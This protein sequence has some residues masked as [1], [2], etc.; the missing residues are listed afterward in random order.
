MNLRIE[1]ELRKYIRRLTADEQA[2]LQASVAAE[3]VR[4]PL[5]VWR[6]NGDYVLLD[7]HHRFEIAQRLGMPFEVR[8]VEL[9]DLSAAKRWMIRNQ[10]GRRNLTPAEAA[11]YRGLEYLEEKK[12]WGGDRRSEASRSSDQNDHLKTAEQLAVEYGV[13]P[14]TVRRDAQFAQALDRLADLRRR[15]R[16]LPETGREYRRAVSLEL[17]FHTALMRLLEPPGVLM[18]P[19]EAFA[20]EDSDD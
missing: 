20:L 12:E 14:A 13:G 18:E 3:G 6:F 9:A 19:L 11:Y 17:G 1:P 2:L 5:V 16:A 8:E 7:G 15:I 4:D 10:L